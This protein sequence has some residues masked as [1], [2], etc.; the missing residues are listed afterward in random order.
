MAES[1]GLRFRTIDLHTHTPASACYRHDHEPEEIVQ[2]ALEKG[3]GAIAVTDHNTA[4]WIDAMKQ[5]A[6]N[7]EVDGRQL[8]IFPGVEISVH[9]GYHVV[10]LFDPSVGQAEVENFLGAIGITP[11]EYGKPDALC[12]KGVYEVLETIHR[13]DGLAVLAHIDEAKGAF[14]EL[15][16]LHPDTGKVKVPLPCARLFNEGAYD[17]VEVTQ[18]ELPEGLD[19]EHHIRRRPAFYQAS[20]NPDPEDP[21][22]HSKDGIGT[23]CSCFNLDEITLEGLRQC[24]ADPD[25]RITLE[26]QPE[27]GRWPHIVEMRV[28]DDGFLAYQRFYFHRGL[29]CLIGGK[30][31]GKSLVIEFLRFALGKPS[32]NKAIRRDHRGK[33]EKQLQPFNEIEV[34]FELANGVRYVLKRT[35]EGNGKS[36]FTCTNRSTGEQYQGSVAQLFP[37]LAYSQTEV[38]K[39]AEDED[40][41]LHLLDSLFDARPYQLAIAQIQDRLDDNDQKLAEALAAR[42]QVEDARQEIATLQERIAN[43]DQMLDNP[44]V[45]R[46]RQAEMKRDALDAQIDYLDR[47]TELRE[48]YEDDVESL[49]PPELPND[50]STDALLVDQ[51]KQAK[52]AR[53][54]FLDALSELSDSLL[55]ALEAVSQAKVNWL[56]TFEEL[57]EEY[58]AELQGSDRGQLEAK[59][60]RLVE[61]KQQWERDL[62]RYQ[63]LAE[64]K[65]PKL[66]EERDELLDR[67]DER[68]R[69]YYEARQKKFDR[70]TEA[71][72]GKLRLTLTHATN[73]GAYEEAISDLLAGSDVG[74]VSTS[75]RRQ[76]AANVAPR[77][78]G[79]FIISRDVDALSEGSGLTE[80]MSKRA[81]DKFWTADDFTQVLAL[82]HAHYPQDT[83]TIEFNKGGGE[84]APLDELSVGQKSTA[85]LIIALCDGTMPVIIDQPEDALDIASVW[86][87]IAKKLRQRKSGRQFILTT[88]NSSLAV[89]SDSDTFMVLTPQSG[90]RARVSYRGAIDRSEVRRAVID[91]LEGGDEP[92]KLR[93]EKYNI[94]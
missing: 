58:I 3:M 47:L 19:A 29:N 51:R 46:M 80:L 60:R 25:V 88:H 55:K 86:E 9:E 18:G 49:A 40:A 4:A 28:G 2:T 22:H 67:L 36:S 83:P 84:F 91:H 74:R 30:G 10:A 13:R 7:V 32:G 71:S 15:T 94:K 21:I 45:Q 78:L 6:E 61:D 87:D 90:D 70:L 16:S 69:S 8:V 85:L 11:Q 43:I 57:R 50:L 34:E 44:L 20:D 38:V 54:A 53:A 76:I 35:Y 66:L 79:R 24:F 14:H 39:I 23:R 56:P 73:R 5:A 59:R 12:D 64:E 27:D 52:A 82:Q 26:E 92:Y 63:T 37:I 1:R 72:E 81:L 17:A 48:T 42:A 89:G 75:N 77:E 65:L 62:K 68:H 33:L 41:Q 31:V 93:Q